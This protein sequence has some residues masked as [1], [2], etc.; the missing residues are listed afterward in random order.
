MGRPSLLTRIDEMT[1]VPKHGAVETRPVLVLE[2]C[3]GS[4]RTAVLEKVLEEWHGKTPS[5]L[6]RPL[7]PPGDAENAV[8][9]VL[10]AIMLGLSLGAPHYNVTFPRV[11]IA[12]IA[13]KENFDGLPA[14]R[15]LARLQTVLNTYRD[16]AALTGFISDLVLAA[17]NLAA[18]IN[19]PGVAAVA[20][21]LAK[22]IAEGITTGLL[23]GHRLARLTWWG[24]PLEWF[25]HQDQGFKFN[26]RLALIKLSNQARNPYF[27]DDVDDL[28]VAA[29]LGD[30]RR[31]LARVNSRPAN[32]LLLL[33]DGDTPPAVAFTRALL[34]VRRSWETIA[35]NPV[36]G[37]PDPLTMITTSGGA[38][39]RALEGHLPDP[40]RL[41]ETQLKPDTALPSGPWLRIALAELPPGDIHQLAKEI[42]WP[43]DIAPRSM[44]S[45]VYRLAR[46]HAASSVF[47]LRKLVENPGAVHALDDLLRGRSPE[48]GCS[49]AR[50][51]LRPFVRDLSERRQVDETGLDALILLS[52][53][54]NLHEAHALAPLLPAPIALDSELFTSSTLWSPGTESTH[55]TLHPVVRYLG[56]WLLAGLP[57]ENPGWNAVFRRL[58][59][60]AD[61]DDRA[62]RLHHDR[63][64]GKRQDVATELAELLPV[65][66]T[67]D[68]LA[69]L[70]EVVATADPR[71]RDIERIKGAG[72]PRNRT[73]RLFVL[74]GVLP[75]LEHD[76]FVNAPSEVSQFRA[77]AE[78]GYLRLADDAKDPTPLILRAKKYSGEGDEFL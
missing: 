48:P 59:N 45:A 6:V 69:L 52:A 31:S 28:L 74:L 75:A 49:I 16:R 34:R 67:A 55:R 22:R 26:P 44:A 71:E 64:L 66:P 14:D 54:R 29:L 57:D 10:A 13:I 1:K 23:R 40:G 62:A 32:A 4:G 63:M 72:Q 39:G 41:T 18:N 5:V 11:V 60:H 33:D 2:G 9:P 20:P 38:L 36:E 37:L 50:Y 43:S 76:P 61:P 58:R 25:G 47:I 27:R 56:L 65:L 8:R 53:A 24:R 46:G 78:Y 73:G 70:D 15:A 30:L 51:L 77:L 17:G 42:E 19:V 3:G 21:P 68:W 7:E 35:G 12:Q